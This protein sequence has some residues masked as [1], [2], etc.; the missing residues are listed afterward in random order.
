[1]NIHFIGIGGIGISA[2]AQFCHHRGDQITGSEAAETNIL[3]RLRTLEIPIEIPQRAS[4]IPLECDLIVY[5]EAVPENNPERVEAKRRHLPQKSYFEYLGEVSKGFRTIA[6]CGTHGKTTTVGLI[7][8]A[9][10]EAHFDATIFIGSTLKVL[11]ESNFHLGT[12]D[13]LLVEA[14]EYRNNF[15][16]IDPEVVVLTNM[17]LDHTDFYKSEAQ[18]F[19]TFHDFCS[20]AKTIICHQGAIDKRFGDSKKKAPEF[21]ISSKNALQNIELSIYGDHNRENAQL[22]LTLGKILKLDLATFKQGLKKYKGAGRRQEYL[23]EKKGI[24][25][26]DDY[27]HHPT[28]IIATLQAF[29]ERFPGKQIG[30]IFEPHQFSRTK[31]FLSAF[32]ESFQQADIVGIFPIYAARDT[33][34]DKQSVSVQDLVEGIDH[35]SLVKN[36]EE[37][38]GLFAKLNKGDVLIFMGAGQIDQ[39]AKSMFL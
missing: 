32:R 12:N 20:K 4:N 2:L 17:E 29:R 23:G 10:Q 30:L 8:S 37:V 21:I 28:E 5:T 33:A 6:V 1:M 31:Q 27:G 35:V 7:A 15:R 13:W 16:F 38:N 26:F 34:E 9:F 25:F 22:A 39:L 19:K 3:S 18:Y 24:K 11:G 36:L 14:C